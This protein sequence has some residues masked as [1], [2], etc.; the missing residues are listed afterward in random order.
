MKNFKYIF[1]LIPI[2]LA[3]SAIDASAQMQ[4]E[5]TASGM[6]AYGVAPKQAKY[7]AKKMKKIRKRVPGKAPKEKQARARAKKSASPTYKKKNN[8]AS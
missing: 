2:L 7:K 1:L 3:S 6:A 5:R 4:P 8:W